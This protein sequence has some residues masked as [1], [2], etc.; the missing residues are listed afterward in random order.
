MSAA[1]NCP[2]SLDCSLIK[3]LTSN[4]VQI[5]QAKKSAQFVRFFDEAKLG[6]H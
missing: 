2:L 5:F 4:R 1:S 6:Q 3:P